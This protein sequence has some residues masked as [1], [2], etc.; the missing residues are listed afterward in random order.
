MT[1][2][3]RKCLMGDE[4]VGETLMLSIAIVKMSMMNVKMMRKAM[5]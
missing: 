3:L 5:T 2:C 4:H 1:R